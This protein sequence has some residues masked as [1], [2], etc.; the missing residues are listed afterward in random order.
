MEVDLEV[1]LGLK[2]PRELLSQFCVSFCFVTKEPDTGHGGPDL[3]LEEENEHS[4]QMRSGI[5]E[6]MDVR[7]I[8][9]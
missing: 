7:R 4:G 6:G 1:V 5:L 3:I 9:T 2:Q 8:L